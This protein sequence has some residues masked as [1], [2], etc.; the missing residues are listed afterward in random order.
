M[1]YSETQMIIFN[2]SPCLKT[3]KVAHYHFRDQLTL[4][5]TPFGDR[6]H[7]LYTCTV[8]GSDKSGFLALV[9]VPHTVVA[10]VIMSPD[11][12]QSMTASAREKLQGVWSSLRSINTEEMESRVASLAKWTP[13]SADEGNPL[14]SMMRTMFGSCTGGADDM[15]KPETSRRSSRS[16]NEQNSPS[17]DDRA[18]ANHAV[19]SLREKAEQREASPSKRISSMRK[20]FPMSSPQHK[21]IVNPY[22]NQEVAPPIP[23]LA[24][25][26]DTFDDGI[27]AISAHTLEELERQNQ[28]KNPHPLTTVKSDLTQDDGL[29]KINP[30]VSKGSSTLFPGSEEERRDCI[31]AATS[32]FPLNRTSWGSRGAGQNRSFQ[33][34]STHSTDFEKMFTQ[35][36]EEYWKD[37]VQKDEIGSKVRKGSVRQ[38][39]M[40]MKERYR[41][42]S[43]DSVSFDCAVVNVLFFSISC[44]L[45]TRYT[46]SFCRS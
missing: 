28:L 2:N 7:I 41:S 39:H 9:E 3:K 19:Q 23:N 40:I 16:S 36:E 25:R 22:L 10:L 42:R 30:T 1:F 18:R 17:S 5:S 43:G 24:S 34:V 21:T 12:R 46:I 37:T 15:T 26:A 6:E 14:E 45:L 27:S 35:N 31:G 44:A 38:L 33:T 32:P 8:G 4:Q 29:E 11:P 20:P 13:R